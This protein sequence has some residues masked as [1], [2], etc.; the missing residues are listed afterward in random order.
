MAF[1]L[2]NDVQLLNPPSTDVG[3]QSYWTIPPETRAALDLDRLTSWLTKYAV[4]YRVGA[5]ATRLHDLLS[6]LPCNAAIADYRRAIVADLQRSPIFRSHL[7]AEIEAYDSGAIAR[8]AYDD[9]LLET[10]DRLSQL[11]VLVDRIAG[12]HRVFSADS[13]ELDSIGLRGLR[14][15]LSRTVEGDLFQELR[16]LLPELRSGLG[17]RRSVTIGVN[18]DDRLRPQS[19][20]LLAIQRGPVSSPSKLQRLLSRVL[21]TDVGGSL[22][23]NE[24]PPSFRDAGGTTPLQPLFRDVHSLLRSI[25]RPVSRALRAYTE[26]DLSVLDRI[27][28]ELALLIGVV[29]AFDRLGERGLA[30]TAAEFKTDTTRF[31]I[32]ISGMYPVLLADDDRPPIDND[33]EINEEDG[34]I[35]ITGPNSGGKTTFIRTLTQSVFLAQHGFP[36][37]AVSARLSRVRAFNTLFAIADSSTEPGA[38][39]RLERELATL[40]SM[41]AEEER[42]GL[43]VLNE[44]FSATG[45]DDALD[46]A[47][48]V[49]R[50]LVERGATVLFVTHLHAL[51]RH[52][53]DIEAFLNGRRVVNL[54]AGVNGG[55]P[56]YKVARSTPE[57]TSYADRLVKM[58]GLDYDSIVSRDRPKTD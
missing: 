16:R 13:T 21:G 4:G 33:V 5:R 57:G 11:E 30:V 2:L 39:G 38:T 55:A 17:E 41:L 14:D 48:S 37:P 32:D 10:I 36:V 40:A 50:G 58:Y 1:D 35:I 6:R 8:Y 9:E 23:T 19:A 15:A 44:A 53:A 43:F 18:L 47:R 28:D 31:S 7:R 25:T 56:T 20:A 52:A 46:I 42:F 27:A 22:Y 3:E 24:L 29:D 51:A 54:V 12:L 26:L 49:L 34:I 45:S